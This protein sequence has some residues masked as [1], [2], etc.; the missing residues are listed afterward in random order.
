MDLGIKGKRALV[1]ASSTGLG[2]AIAQC[3]CRE[4]VLTAICSAHESRAEQTKKDIGAQAS[5]AIDLLRGGAGQLAVRKAKELLG[6]DIDILVTNCPG[7]PKGR[8]L[9][10]SEEVWKLQFQNIFLSVLESVSE[11]LPAMKA[12]QWG[13]IIVVN[14]MV[15]REPMQELAISSSLRPGLLGFIKV[16]SREVAAAGITA[17]SILPSY[18]ATERLSEL[19]VDTSKLTF[20]VPLGRLGKPDE[21]GALATFLASNQAAFITGQA[22]TADGGRQ[23]SI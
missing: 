9:E 12:K 15:A 16:L 3:F 18:T 7:P 8:I 21:V 13:R 20:D 6:G 2:R 22:I 4:G 11:A 23:R 5:F 1:L 10:F 14:S 17:N 19:G